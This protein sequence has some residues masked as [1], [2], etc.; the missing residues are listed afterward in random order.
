MLVL[1]GHFKSLKS[2]VL[3]TSFSYCCHTFLQMRDWCSIGNRVLFWL[4]NVACSICS[5]ITLT[6]II[7]ETLESWRNLRKRLRLVK[8]FLA[9][10][11][12][13][14][15]YIVLLVLVFFV[16]FSC[17]GFF[18]LV[19]FIV[20]IIAVSILVV[21]Y[22]GLYKRRWFESLAIRLFLLLP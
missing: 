12:F 6:A 4:L 11:I 16:H 8:K 3:L 19:R 13:H 1:L 21:L 10:F 18:S 9:K 20:L 15:F 14:V 22:A 5:W 2:S 17:L 7:V